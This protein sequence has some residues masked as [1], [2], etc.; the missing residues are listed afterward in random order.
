MNFSIKKTKKYNEALKIAKGLPNY[1][2]KE[3][4]KKIKSDLRKSI[5]YGL[6][7]D[8][9]FIGFISYKKF[10]KD[11][12]ELEWLAI[13]KEFQNNG[14]GTKIV[15]ES[16]NQIG[17][18]FKICKVK[19]LAEI[20][21]N[22]GYKKTRNFYKKLGFISLEIIQHFPGWKKDNPCQIFVKFLKQ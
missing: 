8:N 6:F 10:N 13:K 5:V 19:T 22:K 3:G 4:I 9:K 16:L 17:K 15:K 12:I 7:Q 18:N 1:F 21:N 14:L 11:V 20:S 2:T